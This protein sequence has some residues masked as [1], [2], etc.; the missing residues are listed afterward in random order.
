MKSKERFVNLTVNQEKM[1]FNYI[2]SEIF[3]YFVYLYAIRLLRLALY[4][5]PLTY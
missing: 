3:R 5:F 4:H 1:P 2:D